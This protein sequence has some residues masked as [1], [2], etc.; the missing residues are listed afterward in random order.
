MC[1][2]GALGRCSEGPRQMGPWGRFLPPQGPGGQE[3][4]KLGQG[5]L[6]RA[7]GECGILVFLKFVESASWS[8]QLVRSPTASDTLLPGHGFGARGENGSRRQVGS[9]RAPTV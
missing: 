8:C 3:R 6:T 4:G 2:P 9:P 1:L 7:V 5:T